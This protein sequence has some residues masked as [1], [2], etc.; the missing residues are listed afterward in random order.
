MTIRDIM[1]PD[2]EYVWPDDTLQEAALKMKELDVGSLPVCDRDRI[3]GLLTD[4][5]ITVRAVAEGRDP[6]S[7]RVREVMTRDVIFC[8]EDEDAEEAARL[9]QARQVRRILVLNRNKRLVGIVSLADLV[10]GTGDPQRIGEV[11]QD[12]SEPAVPGH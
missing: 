11:L 4:R 8:Y 9:M 12:V 7:T 10:A 1:T 2:V 5:D 6:K 3:A